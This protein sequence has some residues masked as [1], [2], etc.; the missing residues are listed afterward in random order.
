MCIRDSPSRFY[1]GRRSS[2]K[3]SFLLVPT[4]YRS[5]VSNLP[6]LRRTLRTSRPRT[7]SLNPSRFL[8]MPH[9]LTLCQILHL[10]H[11]L[12]TLHLLQLLRIHHLHH[13]SLSTQIYFPSLLLLFLCRLL[14][15]LHLLPCL[16][17]AALLLF[18]FLLASLVL[19][20]V[21]FLALS[22][23]LLRLQYNLPALACAQFCNP[24]RLE[25]YRAEAA[26]CGGRFA[27]AIEA[28]ATSDLQG[29]I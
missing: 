1:F 18:H 10:L 8:W 25:M 28:T 6:I 9:L 21:L 14:P 2:S 11:L 17:Q 15:L 3:Y 13:F 16:P 29:G 24:L 23:P 20:L 26:S 27:S 19:L 22:P 4:L 5:I 7:C 12:P